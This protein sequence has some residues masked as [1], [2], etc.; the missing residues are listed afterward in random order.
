LHQRQNKWQKLPYS[1]LGNDPKLCVQNTLLYH[2][3]K[4]Q[5]R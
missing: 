2:M 4:P 5:D 3:T 1:T